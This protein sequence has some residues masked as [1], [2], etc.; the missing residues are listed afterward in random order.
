MKITQEER[1]RR[2]AEIQ[3]KFHSG[4]NIADLARD[5]KISKQ[6]VRLIV[7]GEHTM[8]TEKQIERQKRNAEI[9]KR[10]RSG[11]SFS[12]AAKEAG[13]TR[14]AVAGI[15][16]S[17]GI[18]APPRGGSK[19][20]VLEHPSDAAYRR[21]CRCRGCLKSHAEAVKERK[22]EAKKREITKDE[23]ARDWFPAKLYERAGD[24]WWGR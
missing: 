12:K 1:K 5:H 8:P 18:E 4:A 13:I 23:R 11:I 10:L 3:E 22:A 2:N 6:M 19:P 21:G 14:T 16:K 17:N 20:R 15:A 24:H 7:A 9:I